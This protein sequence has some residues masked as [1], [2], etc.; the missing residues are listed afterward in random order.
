MSKRQLIATRVVSLAML[1]LACAAA[2]AQQNEPPEHDDEQPAPPPH[3]N[4]FAPAPDLQPDPGGGRAWIYTKQGTDWRPFNRFLVEGVEVWHEPGEGYP[5]MDTRDLR[6]LS[7]YLATALV[8]N[9][10]GAL[11]RA[12]EP[13][14]GVLRV[15]AAV[16]RIDATQVP[17]TLGTFLGLSP[18]DARDVQGRPLPLLRALFEAELRDGATGERVM[19][20]IDQ[21][22][23]SQPNRHQPELRWQQLKSAIDTWANKMRRR[24]DASRYGR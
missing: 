21:E 5:G 1:L 12:D 14:P 20:A 3:S 13:G 15:R 8:Q 23:G 9:L 18:R 19:A 6:A 2:W 10:E 16:T 11:S 4:F 22:V 17:H 24:I 7:E